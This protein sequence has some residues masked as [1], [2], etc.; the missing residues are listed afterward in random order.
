MLLEL[1]YQTAPQNNTRLLFRAKRFWPELKPPESEKPLLPWGFQLKALIEI[2]LLEQ[3]DQASESCTLDDDDL[4]MNDR[5]EQKNKDQVLNV[6]PLRSLGVAKGGNISGQAMPPPQEIH[7]GFDPR[8]SGAEDLG[9]QAPSP[10]Y[11]PYPFEEGERSNASMYLG[12]SRRSIMIQ[13]LTLFRKSDLQS[14]KL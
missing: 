12:R 11:L 13:V 8:V 10:Y 1:L 6:L 5:G 7:T 3:E 2:D 14:A 4:D 9:N